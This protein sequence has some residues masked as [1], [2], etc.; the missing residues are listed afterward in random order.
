[1]KVRV[2]SADEEVLEATESV[3]VTTESFRSSE[4]A[5]LCV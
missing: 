3:S 2:P 5:Q 1:M 4:L